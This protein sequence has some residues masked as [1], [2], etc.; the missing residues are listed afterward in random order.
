MKS[1]FLFVFA[2]SFRFL[3]A[4]PTFAQQS[5]GS[6]TL[7]QENWF[8]QIIDDAVRNRLNAPISDQLPNI[9]GDETTSVEEGQQPAESSTDFSGG[10]GRLINVAITD[11]ADAT[12]ARNERRTRTRINPCKCQRGVG[13]SSLIRPLLVDMGE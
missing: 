12:D 2:I 9:L 1:G 5:N 4:E 8:I 3:A 7:K 10:D 11:T 13:G 6:D